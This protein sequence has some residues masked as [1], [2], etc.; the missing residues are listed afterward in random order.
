MRRKCLPCKEMRH[1][2]NSE[3]RK[4]PGLL[5]AVR[6]TRSCEAGLDAGLLL[7]RVTDLHQGR[8][9]RR[10]RTVHRK[11]LYW[12]VLEML[13]RLD[14]WDEYL[15]TW[16]RVRAHTTYALTERPDARQRHGAALTPYVLREDARGLTVHFLWLTRFRKTV[17]ERK[18]QR[19]RR[20][21]KLG[22][23]WHAT[24]DELSGDELRERLTWVARQARE[25]SG[26]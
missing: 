22:N 6:D 4:H 16:A 5:H 20:G 10:E 3:R 11:W 12:F 19:Q 23:V 8:L 18:V 1:I 26:R 14:R 7:L 15:E 17:I 13:D 9:S 24:Q 21:Q 25:A 2:T